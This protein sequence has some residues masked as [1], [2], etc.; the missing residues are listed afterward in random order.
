MVLDKL[1]YQQILRSARY[2]H[3]KDVRSVLN[4]V[5]L[6]A[7]SGVLAVDV[8]PNAHVV[9]QCWTCIKW[10]FKMLIALPWKKHNAGLGRRCGKVSFVY[11][12]VLHSA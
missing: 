10:L 8:Y 2:L 9:N 3:A 11:L 1:L 12:D 4:I 7:I 5:V 6:V